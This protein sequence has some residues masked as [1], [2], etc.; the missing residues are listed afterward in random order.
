MNIFEQTVKAAE[1][2]DLAAQDLLAEAYEA[3]GQP[4]EA[5][6]WLARA[7]KAGKPSA[8]ARLGLWQLSG[9]AVPSNPAEG[10]ARILAA[11]RTG[12]PF[13]L[14][15]AAM[16]E[17]GGIGTPRDIDHAL[18]WLVQAARA[19]DG[20]AAGQLGFLVGQSES[21]KAMAQGAL[22]FAAAS[23]FEPA[24][25]VV[26]AGQPAVPID[27]SAV[28]T[29]AD[30]SAFRTPLNLVPQHPDV[31]IATVSGV[32]PGWACDYV[33]ALA[34]PALQRGEVVT[35]TG[36]EA[37]RDARSNRV[38]HFGLGDS[39]VVIELINHRVAQVAGLPVEYAEG[40]GVLHYAT[41]ERYAP[42]VDYIP[43]TPANAVHLAQ[44]GQRVRTVLVYLNDDF[45]GG[46]TEFP[47]L[48]L[49]LKPP[50]GSAIV[51]DSVTADGATDPRTLHVGAA[52]TRGEKWIIS[53]WFRTRPLRPGEPD[54]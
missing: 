49:K 19:G 46:C 25:R 47:R 44:R 39:D 35:E 16:I 10:A 23:G 41:G 51:F 29:A 7:A 20:R 32:L 27:W 52:P 24:R 2:G 3:M 50:R 33:T 38:M 1:A 42:H 30:L 13:G 40:L 45:D 54:A 4:A 37:V 22:D 43:E 17:A 53:K 26:G 15:L 11:A 21:Y 36:A 48:D 8:H 5:L 12:D 9:Y 18:Q 6:T 31:R 34:E 28:A 14:S